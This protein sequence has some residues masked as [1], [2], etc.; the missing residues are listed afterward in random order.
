M[1]E[2]ATWQ[3]P[4]PAGT[5]RFCDGYLF[6]QDMAERVDAILDDFDISLAAVQVVPL[7]RVSSTVTNNLVAGELMTYST[8]DFDTDNL[9]LQAA[10]GT[11][12][13]KALTYY[14]AGATSF[15]RNVGGTAGN[16]STNYVDATDGSVFTWNQRDPATSAGSQSSFGGLHS[17]TLT[18]NGQITLQFGGSGTYTSINV[19]T[20][21]FWIVKTGDV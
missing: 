15:F 1:P 10:F 21:Y 12:T 4:Y 11:L 14:Q 17:N 2:T 6:I 18:T 3:I 9:A 20:V 8:I 16:T 13:A 19:F 7:A 5:D